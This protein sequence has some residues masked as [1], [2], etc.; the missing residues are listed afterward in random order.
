LSSPKSLTDGEKHL[1]RL[2][3]AHDFTERLYSGRHF[4]VVESAAFIIAA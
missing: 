2:G 4:G 3:A 1:H